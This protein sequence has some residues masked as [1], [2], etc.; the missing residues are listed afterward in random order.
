[1]DLGNSSTVF[2]AGLKLAHFPIAAQIE[3][4]AAAMMDSSLNKNICLKL[5]K[6]RMPIFLPGEKQGRTI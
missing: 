3:A 2:A 1:M 6:A 5:A 4:A